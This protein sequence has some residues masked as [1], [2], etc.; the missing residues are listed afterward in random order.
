MWP[1]QALLAGTYQKV[2]SHSLSRLKEL[3]ILA[4][5]EGSGSRWSCWELEQFKKLLETW[6]ACLFV[7]AAILC[8]DAA[9]GINHTS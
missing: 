7:V 3:T 8:D 2:Y 4:G 1:V 5:L 6:Q 9:K